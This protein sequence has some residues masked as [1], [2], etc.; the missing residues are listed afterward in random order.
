MGTLKKELT[1][2]G[3]GL[4]KNQECTVVIK[5]IAA[6]GGYAVFDNDASNQRVSGKGTVTVS[7]RPGARNGQQ[8]ILIQPPGHVFPAGA[9]GDDFCMLVR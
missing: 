2:K 7:H 6:D 5:R 9:A 4:M 3:N 8:P 1:I